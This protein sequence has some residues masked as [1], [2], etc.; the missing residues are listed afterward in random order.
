MPPELLHVC[1]GFGSKLSQ[2]AVSKKRKGSH[3]EMPE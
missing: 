1:H 2:K 3:R